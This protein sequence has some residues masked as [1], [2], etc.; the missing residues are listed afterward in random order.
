MDKLKILSL[1]LPY[2]LKGKEYSN[3][4]RTF[5]L[6][7][8]CSSCKQP[9]VWSEIGGLSSRIDCIPI[10]RPLSDLEDNKF[11]SI[12]VQSDI[13]NILD[14]Y[15]IDGSLDTIEYYLVEK[16]LSLHFDIFNLIKKS[17]AIDINSLK[18]EN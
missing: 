13:D 15:R 3:S 14:V 12:F 16:L 9:A 2:K 4:N 10:L 5:E 8:V 11:E 17:F 6:D 18:N 7:E 1:Y